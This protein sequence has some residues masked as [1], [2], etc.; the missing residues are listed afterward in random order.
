MN[1][2]LEIIERKK[3]TPTPTTEFFCD[4]HGDDWRNNPAV[5]SVTVGGVGYHNG[6]SFDLCRPCADSDV[7]FELYRK[8]AEADEDE[9]RH[10]EF[11][12]EKDR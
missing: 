11:D 1:G 12:K 9:R 4:G 7:P 8:A 3:L 2:E 5:E 10:D 6:H